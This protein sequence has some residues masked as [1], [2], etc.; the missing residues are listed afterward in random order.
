M[1]T[2]ASPLHQPAAT[3]QLHG[4]WLFAFD[5]GL[6]RPEHLEESEDDLLLVQVELGEPPQRVAANCKPPPQWHTVDVRM[7]QA[8]YPGNGFGLRPFFGDRIEVALQANLATAIARVQRENRVCHS[9]RRA[10]RHG[11]RLAEHRQRGFDD[12]L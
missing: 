4:A 11:S 1:K 2:G 9:R 3:N 8:L 6:E 10:L 5:E 12:G 7:T